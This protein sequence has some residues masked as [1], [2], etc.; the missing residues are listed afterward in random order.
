M[1]K[2]TNL[3]TL[4]FVNAKSL[5]LLVKLVGCGYSHVFL[6]GKFSGLFSLSVVFRGTEFVI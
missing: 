6:L 5:T 3:C 4:P 1:R 2:I